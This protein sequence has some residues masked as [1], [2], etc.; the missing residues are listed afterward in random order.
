MLSTQSAQSGRNVLLCDTT[1]QVEK[2]IK[3]T[4]ITDS[5]AF[6]IH[7]IHDSLSIITGA[8][9]SSFFVLFNSTIKD[10]ADRFDQIFICTT[11]KNTI[12]IN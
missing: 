1:G 11:D 2:E 12:R 6:H 7:N 9:C 8:V 3:D 10:L 4:I 5:P